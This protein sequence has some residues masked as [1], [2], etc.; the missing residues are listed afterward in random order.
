[1]MIFVDENPNCGWVERV[2]Q[3]SGPVRPV[4]QIQVE[5]PSGQHEWCEVM[6]VDA[7]GE[8][9][10]AFA[11]VVDDS[12][13]GTAWL[14]YGGAWGIRYRTAGNTDPW[15]LKDANQWGEPFKVLDSSGAEI[16]FKN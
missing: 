14:V 6:G 8:F 9:K 3:E 1:M 4:A 13:A 16:R 12:G 2:F 11:V 10:T 7:N 15:S 5:T